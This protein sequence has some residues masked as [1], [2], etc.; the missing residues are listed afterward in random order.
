MMG[1]VSCSSLPPDI[2]QGINNG[3]PHAY[4]EAG[5]HIDNGKTIDNCPDGL[6]LLCTTADLAL[7]PVNIL[8]FA[9]T[10]DEDKQLS[11]EN[12]FGYSNSNSSKNREAAEYYSKGAE[13]GDKDCL[14]EM[15]RNYEN[16][17]GV[18]QDLSKA[19]VYYT[20]AS[21]MGQA[22]AGNALH[23]L[24]CAPAS[25]KG[26]R[27]RITTNA[28]WNGL[29]TIVQDGVQT[30]A[31]GGDFTVTYKKTGVNTGWLEINLQGSDHSTVHYDLRFT[32]SHTAVITGGT[33]AATMYDPSAKGRR[34][35]TEKLKNVK[36][37]CTFN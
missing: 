26:K 3:T 2:A 16:G 14:Y 24:T 11:L 8:V 31:D 17:W 25:V 19:K 23:E 30:D 10:F 32:N 37:T 5:K 9:A 28:E 35:F 7:L 12:C 4:Y 13:L 36:G 33:T 20:K 34:R 6:R 1:M 27:L 22:Q 18:N 15:G 21:Q 29:N